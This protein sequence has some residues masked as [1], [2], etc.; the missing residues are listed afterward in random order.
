MKL[1]LPRRARKRVLTR[2][3]QPLQTVQALNK[4]WSLDFMRDTLYDGRKHPPNPTLTPATA[5][6]P[7]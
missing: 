6:V 7:S 4:V 5:A 1:N 2:D 3:P